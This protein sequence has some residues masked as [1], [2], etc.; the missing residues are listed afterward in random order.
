MELVPGAGAQ[1]RSSSS[2]WL[3]EHRQVPFVLPQYSSFTLPDDPSSRAAFLFSSG[4]ALLPS[5]HLPSQSVAGF[6]S[7]LSQVKAPE[8]PVTSFAPAG[9]A[10]SQPSA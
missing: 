8:S 3:P 4:F 9:A 1:R 6:H 5:V 7:V 10:E 2:F